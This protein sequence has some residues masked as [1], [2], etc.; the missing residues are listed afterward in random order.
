MSQLERIMEFP[1]EVLSMEYP[2]IMTEQEEKKAQATTTEKPSTTM[3]PSLEKIMEQPLGVQNMESMRKEDRDK[4]TGTEKPKPSMKAFIKN[5][6]FG[7][8]R[9]PC[10]LLK[11]IMH[12]ICFS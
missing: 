10:L 9:D 4:N 3:I 5:S 7:N 8:N 12:N 11:T 6:I 2:E 1:L